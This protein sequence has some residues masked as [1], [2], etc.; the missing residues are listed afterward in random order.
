MKIIIVGCGKVG[1]S[2]AK[3]LNEDGNDIV[4][5]D[6]N[7]D[8]I[9]K[10]TSTLDVM[11]IVGNGT[12]HA[13]QVEAGVKDADLLLAVT[14]SDEQ[15]LLTCLMAKIAGNCRTIARVRNHIYNEEINFIRNELGLSMT[16][17][18]EEAS[19]KEI[20]RILKYPSATKVDTFAKGRVELMTLR[21]PDDSILDNKR[22]MDII[23]SLKTNVLICAVERG[24]E[25]IIPDGSFVLKAK[26]K[27]SIIIQPSEIHKFFK[28]ISLNVKKVKDAMIVGGGRIAHYLAKELIEND[29]KVKI[30]D[31]NHKRC[32]ELSELLPNATIIHGDGTDQALLLE[33][34]I[35]TTD[36]FIS[37]TNLDE[38]NILL[39]LYA[40]SITKGKVVTKI[41]RITFK[42]VINNLNIGSLV[43]PKAVTA[44][45]ILQY[46]RALKNASGNNVETL[47]Q[48]VED[49]VEAL[50]FKV[51]DKA[52]VI[53]T[54]LSQLNLKKNLLICCIIRDER[55][56]TPGGK[57]EIKVGDVVI[58]VTTNRGLTDL[59]DILQEEV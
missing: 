26:D 21:I 13:I 5:I 54:S 51:N 49:K 28:K 12:S 56:I 48:I 1:S 57:D 25:T 27:I 20:A 41:D 15:N 42:S 16:I 22:I 58:V 44:S 45:N 30:I 46:V 52:R 36:A 32:Q 40:D 14:D 7:A 39:S 31:I 43:S 3:S 2:L 50:A 29:I 38:E 33:E 9:D 47:Y 53:N 23:P 24:E 34:G 59:N 10:I 17:N 11:G 8:L 4:I 18:P 19:A 6:K 55:I 37:L 35:E